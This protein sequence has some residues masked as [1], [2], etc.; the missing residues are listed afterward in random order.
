MKESDY[1]I[2]EEIKRSI[3]E[4]K[5]QLEV[6]EDI[7]TTT[8]NDVY[9]QNEMQNNIINTGIEIEDKK[10]ANEQKL[11]ETRQKIKMI[12]DKNKMPENKLLRDKKWYRLFDSESK[13]MKNVKKTLDK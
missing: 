13:E 11:S 12:M 5:K 1:E 10:L 8:K 3:E 2:Y 7:I 9:L 4:K 6:S